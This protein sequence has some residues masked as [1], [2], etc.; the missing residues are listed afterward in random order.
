MIFISSNNSLTMEFVDDENKFW[1]HK[2]EFNLIEN[3]DV[4]KCIGSK[5]LSSDKT[6]FSR[7]DKND[8]ILLFT[9]FKGNTIFYGFT[10]VEN[11]ESNNK[12]LYNHYSNK[13]KLKI[14]R[15]KYFLEP[16]YIEDFYENVSFVKNKENYKRYFINEYKK[17]SKE[18]FKLILKQSTSTGMFPVYLDE[19]HKNM[20]EFILDTCKSLHNILKSQDDNSLIEINKFISI[21]KIS[22]EGY[23]IEKD[24]EDL[25]RF[26]SRYAHELGFKHIAAR[27]PK[28]F[29]VLLS[30]SGE[31]KNYVYIN[32]E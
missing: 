27:D 8:E 23:G 31:K 22:L 12:T 10:K 13:T 32:L 1:I 6:T 30:P 20:K 11:V 3:I 16:I 9:R 4:D 14:K 28:K 29:V 7:I 17:I 24:L 25:K 18:D 26:Y 21:L 19:Y 15:I 2:V 5:F